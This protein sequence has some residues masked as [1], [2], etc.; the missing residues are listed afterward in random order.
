[1]RMRALLHSGA[2]EG[3]GATGGDGRVKVRG[4]PGAAVCSLLP[5]GVL[6]SSPSS[7]LAAAKYTFRSTL[8]EPVW[9]QNTLWAFAST[10]KLSHRPSHAQTFS[11]GP[12]LL[13]TQTWHP[14]I[15]TAE[16]LGGVPYST[17]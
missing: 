17:S 6:I 9:G 3:E 2:G 7:G 5:V 16:R 8:T 13:W 11:L 15:R 12:S 4:V 10:L 1:M 14:Q